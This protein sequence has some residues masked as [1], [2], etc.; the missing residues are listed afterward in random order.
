[1]AGEACSTI[2]CL[3]GYYFDPDVY[4]ALKCLGQGVWSYNY[5]TCS[6]GPFYKVMDA[7]VDA[8]AAGTAISTARECVSAYAA[9]RDPHFSEYSRDV[10]Q[11]A[12]AGV[13]PGCSAQC[14]LDCAPH[15]NARFDS[16][17]S[18]AASGEFRP[19]CAI[20]MDPVGGVAQDPLRFKSYLEGHWDSIY[21]QNAIINS[22]TERC[23]QASSSGVYCDV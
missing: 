1:M 8:C 13:P 9:L 17:G 7:G 22:S 5:I 21:S 20:P 3:P 12:W 11:G 15:F 4:G 19:I 10:L 23:A 18:R 6:Q 2:F 16:D 14:G